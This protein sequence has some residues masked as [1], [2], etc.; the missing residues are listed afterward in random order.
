[1]TTDLHKM[2]EQVA[3]VADR[4]AAVADALQG[5]GTR[6][7]GGA[8]RWWLLPAAGVVAVFAAR[9]GPDLIRQARELVD[10]AKEQ[11]ASIGIDV[12][13]LTKEGSPRSENKQRN[14][15]SSAKERSARSGRRQQRRKAT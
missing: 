13:L 2:A 6:R 10:Q 11:A 7:G 9:K 12:D 1:M 8:G 5:K 3:D 4:I 15:S 14:T